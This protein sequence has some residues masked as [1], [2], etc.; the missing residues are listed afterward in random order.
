[1][2]TT[3]QSVQDYIDGIRSGKIVAGRWVRHA[4]ERHCYDLQNGSKRGYHFDEKL[5]DLA[6]FFFPTCL[7]FTK[8]EW[9]GKQFDLSESQLFIIWCLFGWRRE[10]GTRRFRYAYLTAGRKWGKSEFAAGIALLLT[11]LDYPCEPAAEVYCAATKEEQAKI[12]FNVAKEMARTSE[13]LA[14]QCK[15]LAKSILVNEEGYQPNS[16]LK[17]IGSDSKTSDG[18]N[19][20]GAVLDEIHEWRDRHVGLYDKLTTASGARRQ[21]LIVMITTAGDDQS[22][23]WNAVDDLCT[24]TLTDYKSE[25]PIGDTYFAFIARIDDAWIDDNGIEHPADDPHDPACWKKANPNYPITPKH[26]Y[27]KEQSNTAKSGPLELNKFL[28]YCCNVKVKSNEKAI[29]DKLWEMSAGELTDWSKAEAVCGAW[30]LGGRDDLASVSLVARFCVGQDHN[31]ESQYRYEI[32]QR[33]FINSENNRDVTKEPWIDYVRKGLLVVSPSEL[34]ELKATCKQ[35]WREYRAKDWAYDPHTSRDVAQDLT[36]E[37]L[38]CVEFYQNCSMYNEPLRTFLKALKA[39]AI[40]HDGN[41]ILAWAAS[42]LVTTSN[43][44]GEVMPDKR[45]SKEKIDPIVS[46]IMAFRLASLAPQ[47]AKGALFVF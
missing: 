4:V 5:A 24:K 7:R 16:F 36:S 1:M 43:H 31:G 34:N 6:C 41:Q 8:G 44:K 35:Y 22:T 12:V 27:L 14:A 3:K 9:A 15:P 2:K 42:N 19:I 30:D 28:R 29:D 26:D 45:S 23:V 25:D 13:I 37:G 46:T 39:G 10:D 32:R 47:R 20:H 11:I 33:S 38:K 17:P 18:L 21:P 40:R